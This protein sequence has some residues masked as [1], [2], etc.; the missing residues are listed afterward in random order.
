MRRVIHGELFDRDGAL[1][2]LMANWSSAV[3]FAYQRFR[4]GLD[5]NDVRQRVKAQLN[6]EQFITVA[7]GDIILTFALLAP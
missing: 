6:G 7:A 1:R 4:E 3:R 5:F 2:P